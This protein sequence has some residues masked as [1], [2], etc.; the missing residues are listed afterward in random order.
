MFIA[1]AFA[2]W[3][4]VDSE[5]Y[6]AISHLTHIDIQS[7]SDLYTVVHE[8]GYKL[9][10]A[11]FF[12]DLR[13]HIGEWEAIKHFADFAPNM[14]P[15][16]TQ[17]GW[18]FALGEHGLTNVK[19]VGDA[20]KTLAAHFDKYPNISVILNGDAAHIPADALW[21]DPAQPF[22]AA[23]FAH[24]HVIVD[25]LLT[26]AHTGAEAHA[27]IDALQNPVPFHFPWVT[28]VVSCVVEGNLV[29][30]GHTSL[31]RAAKNA[32]VTTTG[33]TAGSVVG[34]L[35]GGAAAGMVFG[36]P[37]AI[38]GALIG[39]VAG[40]FAGRMAAREIN[41]MPF[42]EAEQQF[43]VAE[44]SL[45]REAARES[46]RLDKEWG[47]VLNEHNNRLSDKLQVIE[48]HSAMQLESAKSKSDARLHQIRTEMRTEIV[49]VCALLDEEL[50]RL[51]RAARF[52]SW[53][54]Q[55]L[56]SARAE[57]QAYKL[58]AEG[59]SNDIV[60]LGD[61]LGAVSQQRYR[62]E[63]QINSLLKLRSTFVL[64]VEK[65]ATTAISDAALARAQAIQ[66]L[67]TAWNEAE[68]KLKRALEP[69]TNAFADAKADY[70]RER[71][72]AGR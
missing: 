35:A 47:I 15:T 8:E 68:Q 21:F 30:R 3:D 67:K 27:A 46:K 11:G 36:P 25:P 52:F 43:K 40:A 59:A 1:G 28:L 7:F 33:V 66:R 6:Q 69:V 42:N 19:V 37:G 48:R 23:A 16:A 64:A 49:A 12:Y 9:A 65:A 57:I 31:V 2:Q 70:D 10:S 22:D 60:E 18:D 5:V 71:L 61:L 39:G 24:G 63:A 41:L 20:T 51:E 72:A 58:A 26:A 56:P 17:P 32:T 55:R 38:V 44:T 54:K 45:R 29:A 4:R 53:A 50:R 14:A 34:K 13:G 62:Q